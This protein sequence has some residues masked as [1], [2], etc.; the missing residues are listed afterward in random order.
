M[1]DREPVARLLYR[2][3]GE[4]AEWKNY[5]G[6]PMPEWDEL[7]DAIREHWSAVADCSSALARATETVDALPAATLA[8]GM[9]VARPEYPLTSVVDEALA[10]VERLHDALAAAAR[11]KQS[12]LWLE[13]PSDADAEIVED[14][15]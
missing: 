4:S 2:A 13:E 14:E 9:V 12:R 7:P 5:R 15:S 6:D 1:S 8:A 3:Y 10:Q 11:E